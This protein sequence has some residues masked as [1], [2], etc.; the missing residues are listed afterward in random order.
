[1]VAQDK[2]KLSVAGALHLPL[3]VPNWNKVNIPSPLKRPIAVDHGR[4]R[5]LHSPALARG[6]S[7]WLT[8]RT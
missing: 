6:M 1:M 2:F 3:K 4:R 8:M 5:G 7:R